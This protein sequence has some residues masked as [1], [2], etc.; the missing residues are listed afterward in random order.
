M[1]GRAGRQGDP[2]TSRFFI[3]LDD[4][5][6]RIFGGDR[7]KNMVKQFN[8]DDDTPLESNFLN[9]ALD[10]AQQKVEDFYYDSRKKIFD[11]DE[12]LNRQRVAIYRERKAILLSKSV[13]SEMIAYG[14]SL[15]CD[16]I[17]EA[18][19]LKI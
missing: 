8:L 10:K 7:I 4:S 14:E 13:R 12:V 9:N 15:I 17:E 19:R 2:G 16:I 5:V 18:E 1:R 11:Y 3:S 6:F